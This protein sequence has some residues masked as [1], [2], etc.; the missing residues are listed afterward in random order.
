MQVTGSRDVPG[1]LIVRGYGVILREWQE[2]DLAVLIDL[3]DEPSVDFWT[4]LPSPFDMNAA[5]HHVTAARR[6]MRN[7]RNLRL[8]ITQDE[9]T[10]LGEVLLMAREGSTAEIAYVV[11]LRHR[12][13]HIAT[14][15]VRL[16][17]KYALAELGV[18]SFTLEISPGN[19]PSQNVAR[20]CG[21][22]LTDHPVI[23]KRRKGRNI[24][25]A[26]WKCDIPR[27]AHQPDEP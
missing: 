16:T 15:S 3:F 21:F 17:M 11:G 7:R 5:T 13:K 4:P 22:H 14:S 20:A 27:E 19:I 26:V 8:A 2:K 6:M 25:L 1:S 10:P 24:A 12:G 9:L 18:D 23:I